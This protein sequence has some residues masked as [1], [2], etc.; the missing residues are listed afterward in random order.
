MR[1]WLFNLGYLWLAGFIWPWFVFKYLTTGKYRAGIAQRLGGLPPRAGKRSIWVHAV[2]VGELLQIKPLLKALRERHAELDVVVTYTTKTAAE[3]AARE[4]PDYYHCYSPLDLSWVVAK[5]FRVL[6]PALL[7][8][9]ELELWP[10]WLM[11]A[12][13]K[14]VPV[15]LANGRISEKS[16][17]N[18]R[19]FAWLL[20]P[21][22]NAI[23]VW[24]MQDEAY[25]QRAQALAGTGSRSASDGNAGRPTPNTEHRTPNVQVVANL[26]Y[27]ALRAEPDAEKVVAFK[28]MFSIA[29]GQ[30]V[31][32]CGS[33]HPGEHE[34]IVEMLPRLG[35]RAIIVPRHPERYASVREMLTRAGIPWRN[36]SELSADSP[37]GAND[38]ILLDTVGE[39]AAV[40]GVADV[41]F[42][43]GSLIPHGGQNMAEPIALGKATLYGP[44][45]HNFK[46]TV[47]ELRECSG[48]IEVQNA[49]ELERELK[50]LLQDDAARTKLGQAGREKLLAGRGALERHL[51]LIAELLRE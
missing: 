30:R 43:G 23:N 24:A 48:A 2:S 17:R 14:G 3:I 28:A 25:A 29:D 21:A 32:V 45:T 36:R 39:L 40:Y 26:K 4:L 41:V 35:C 38:V 46:A 50:R 9:I 8:L 42:I 44:H 11:H 15:L 31:L 49:A 22:Y 16:F 51:K 10:N 20:Q 5:F 34:I 6:N 27:D 7:V 18:Y 19:R 1:R 13:R 33:T 47:R 12:C 37:A